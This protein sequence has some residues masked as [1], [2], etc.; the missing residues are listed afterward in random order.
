L[1]DP[2]GFEHYEPP[3]PVNITG[4]PLGRPLGLPIQSHWVN[5]R[6][7]SEGAGYSLDNLVSYDWVSTGVPGCKPCNLYGFLQQLLLGQ[8]VDLTGFPPVVL[9]G[10]AKHNHRFSHLKQVENLLA[11]TRGMFS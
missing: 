1:P 4:F 2:E 11:L 10:S 9:S 7:Q 3:P 6:Y 8:P 5:W